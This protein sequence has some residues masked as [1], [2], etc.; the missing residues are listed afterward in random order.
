MN[1]TKGARLADRLKT[2]AEA[3]QALLAK[4]K[5]R[6][7][8]ADPL[9]AERGVE[10]AA[11]LKAVRAERQAVRAV[12]KAAVDA[13]AAGALALAELKAARKRAKAPTA[14][15]AKD[16]RDAKYAARKSRL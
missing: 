11:E 4:F 13:A 6:P 7:A 9:F 12:R 10:A 16:K 2:A 8:A 5:P 15:E 14:A 1:E 3:K